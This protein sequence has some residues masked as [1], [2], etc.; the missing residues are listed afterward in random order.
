MEFG[1][2]SK[3][4][5]SGEEPF[6]RLDAEYVAPSLLKAEARIQER[7]G[8]VLST[9]VDRYDGPTLNKRYADEDLLVS[10][11]AIDSVDTEDGLT[12]SEE[13][14]Y[15][16]RPSRAK[17]LLRSGDLLVSNVRPN[18]NAVSLVTQRHEKALASSG[19]TLLRPRGDVRIPQEFLFAFLKT[20]FGRDQLVRRNRGSM[21]PAV[22]SRDVV[23]IRIP[24][25]ST[26]LAKKVVE[27]IRH[28]LGLHDSFF[29]LLENQKQRLAE[30]L[31]P[32][33]A[34]PSPLE[35][36]RNGV[37]WTSVTKRDCF[38]LGGA[39]RL[40]AEFFRQEYHEF[41]KRCQE[42]N[43]LSSSG[44]TTPYRQVADW[45]TDMMRFRT[46]SKQY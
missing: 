9:I 46:S 16:D 19:F 3:M 41:D 40:D 14:L 29:G 18:R 36:F 8:R 7:G 32:L 27:G 24:V 20:R 12:Y 4:V 42:R 25:P 34:P 39:L 43:L 13:L 2:T 10:Y 33:G 15:K 35:S 6:L 28:A 26:S 38:A 45:V 30:Y 22:L 5:L 44:S 31:A 23:D 1:I 21:Y 37:D 17:Y 11:V